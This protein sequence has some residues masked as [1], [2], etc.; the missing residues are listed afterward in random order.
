M[1]KRI[2]RF[3]TNDGEEFTT[4]KKAEEHVL[5]KAQETLAN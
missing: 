4:Y 5:D 3:Q 2:E 1:I